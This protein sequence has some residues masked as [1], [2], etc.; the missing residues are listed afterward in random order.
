M[1]DRSI[2]AN[3]LFCKLTQE[4]KAEIISSCA[5]LL[6]LLNPVVQESAG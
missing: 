2:E 3:K 1:K 4:Q 6:E 5:A